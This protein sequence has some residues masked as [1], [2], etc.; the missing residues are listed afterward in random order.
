MTHLLNPCLWYDN[1][2]NQAAEFYGSVFGKL[3][4]ISE[5]PIV[6]VFELHGEKFM[7]LNGGPMFKFNP[8]CSIFAVCETIEEIDN[9]WQKLSEGGSPLMPLDKYPWSER[10]GWIQDK[11]GLSWQLMITKKG[12][13]AQKFSPLLMFFGEQ[14]GNAEKAINFYTTV[15]KNS[16]IKSIA[17]YEE[18]EGDVTGRGKHA[19]FT[20]NNYTM[21]AMESSGPHK[22]AFNE[23]FSIVVACDTQEEIDYYWNTFT[24]DGGQESMCGWLKDKFGVSWQIT[25]AILG[26]FMNDPVKAPKVMQAFM[27]MKKFN[28][29]E[30]EAAAQ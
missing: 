17:R 27:K 10:F 11:F 15:F 28:I 26:K 3:K 8:S 6:V 9:A 12:D 16:S 4:I 24:A 5:N 14:N 19:Q 2:A 21:M 1:N 25:P 20:A 22:F 30:L 13:V 29:A 23:A 18:G 7:A